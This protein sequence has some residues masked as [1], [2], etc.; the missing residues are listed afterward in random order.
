MT[1]GPT[2]V[3]R[4]REARRLALLRLLA[5]A[6]AYQAADLL[7]YQ[8]LPEQGVAASL[9]AVRGDI[10]WLAEQGLVE[11]SEA[12]TVRLA[13]ITPRGLDASAG[14]AEVPGVARP[15]PGT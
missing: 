8:A 1:H 6:P 13:R 10:A 4:L 9:D 7:L 11:V 3:E 15:G 12:G 2:F 5:A 14:L